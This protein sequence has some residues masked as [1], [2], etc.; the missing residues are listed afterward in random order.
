MRPLIKFF[1]GL[2]AIILLLIGVGFCAIGAYGWINPSL[3]VGD[4]NTK[5]LVLGIFIAVGVAIVG[6][7]A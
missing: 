3:F 1:T 6:A 5:N 4:D 2:G 7:A